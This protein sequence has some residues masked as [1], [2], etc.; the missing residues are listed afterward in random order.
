M[1]PDFHE[2]LDQLQ[3]GLQV[4]LVNIVMCFFVKNKLTG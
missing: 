2:L 3:E 1:N 4:L